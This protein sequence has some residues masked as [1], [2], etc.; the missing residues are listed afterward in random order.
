MEWM[1][2]TEGRPRLR[3]TML[4]VDTSSSVR[5]PSS[6][7]GTALSTATTDPLTPSCNLLS[8]ISTSRYKYWIQAEQSHEL[9]HGRMY[10]IKGVKQC[11]VK[12]NLNTR[13]HN[14]FCWELEKQVKMGRRRRLGRT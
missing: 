10:T 9:P 6:R 5:V 12:S 14:S 3:L 1:D 11:K 2:G 7:R 8:L 13:K 4:E